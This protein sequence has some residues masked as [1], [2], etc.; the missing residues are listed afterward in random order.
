M[1]RRSLLLLLA[2]M[3]HAGPA[4]AGAEPLRAGWMHGRFGVMTH[5]LHDWP[6]TMY[7]TDEAPNFATFAAAARAGNPHALHHAA[8]RLPR[9]RSRRSAA[10][11]RPAA[12][13]RAGGW[14]AD[15]FPQLPRRHLGRGAPRFGADEV[16]AF[17]CRVAE[18]G[19]AVTWDVP[20]R[21][22]GTFA[23]E[24]LA[25]LQAVAAALRAPPVRTAA[26]PAP[27]GNVTSNE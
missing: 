24:Y 19:G 16:A 13:R 20:T 9:R 15:P 4:P 12:R 2:A 14:R 3:L 5:Y 17:S 6:N 18:V 26:P 1:C 11:E 7:R 25:Q 10:V 27:T 21:P 8:R 22:D 23:P